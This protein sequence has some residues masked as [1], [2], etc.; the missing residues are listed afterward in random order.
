[1]GAA[2]STFKTASYTATRVLPA[3]V[4]AE[5]RVTT[6]AAGGLLARVRRGAEV[7]ATLRAADDDGKVIREPT[8]VVVEE[9]DD[10]S[11]R[12]VETGITRP[13]DAAILLPQVAD[14][15]IE[16]RQPLLS[17]VGG[18]VVDHDQLEVLKSSGRA[19]SRL[20]VERTAAAGTWA[21][22]RRRRAQRSPTDRR[23]SG[24]EIT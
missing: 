9:G 1:M 13:L 21:R 15:P 24:S 6:G 4:T 7:L 3:T 20:R 5:E 10:R 8:V 18:A 16:S 22:S 14:P 12:P 19:R 23:P 2:R 11:P 17:A